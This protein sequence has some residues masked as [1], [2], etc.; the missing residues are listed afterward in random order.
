M[1]GI[2]KL[3]KPYKDHPLYGVS[4]FKAGF[5]GGIENFLGCLDLPVS[6]VRARA[7]DGVEPLYF[8]AYQRLKGDVYY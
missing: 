5:G 4:K 8:R 3:D 6:R 2:S 1:W 7:W